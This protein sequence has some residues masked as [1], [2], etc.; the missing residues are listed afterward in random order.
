MITIQTIYLLI[1]KK[2]ISLCSVNLNLKI[3]LSG[4][5]TM[6]MNIKLLLMCITFQ[7]KQILPIVI[8]LDNFYRKMNF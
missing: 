8:I 3:A 6:Q 4:H 7:M 2:Q 5:S 1:K